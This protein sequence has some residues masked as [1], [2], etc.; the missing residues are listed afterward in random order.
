MSNV[1]KVKAPKAPKVKKPGFFAWLKAAWNDNSITDPLVCKRTLQGIIF[2]VFG[3]TLILGMCFA[4]L[5]PILK[6]FPM[7][8]SD[9]EDLGNPDVVWVPINYSIISFQAAIRLVF[10]N[11]STMFLSLLY[12]AVTAFIQVVI[13]AMAGYTIGRIKIPFKGLIF[14]LVVFQFVV[15]PQSLLISQYLNF[16]NFDI[17]G[18]FQLTTG[19]TIDLINNPVTLY[20]LSLLGQGLKQS[21]FIYIFSSFFQ[22]LPKELEEAALID[23]C[24]FYKTYLKI[25]LPNAVPSIMVV[26]VLSFIWNY[27]D[28]Y[29]TG[30]FHPEGPYLAMKLNQQF[31][32]TNANTVVDAVSKWYDKPA[33]SSFTYDAVKQA[34]VLIYLIPLLVIYFIVQKKLVENFAASGIVG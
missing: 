31:A 33:A 22:G 19:D 7:V 6:L 12:A 20:M 15:P 29:Y 18:I 16:K 27:G 28:T 10:G 23:G 21:L 9:V 4:I 32:A 30:Y 1:K 13:C 24:G 3:I 14:G 26:A 34:A 17:L 11:F 8:L 2:K 25:A 5:Y